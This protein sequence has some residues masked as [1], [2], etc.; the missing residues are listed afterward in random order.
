MFAA[1]LLPSPCLP[2]LLQIV[3]IRNF[4]CGQNSHLML[5][6]AS[7]YQLFCH[8]ARKSI[9]LFQ[10]VFQPFF[11]CFFFFFITCFAFQLRAINEFLIART[12]FNVKSCHN[13]CN[14]T[15]S[16]VSYSSIPPPPL[17]QLPCSHH[18]AGQVIMS[19]S[20]SCSRLVSLVCKSLKSL[21]GCNLLNAS[22]KSFHNEDCFQVNQL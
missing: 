10:R 22:V 21:S 19:G 7:I 2:E 11:C 4:V 3:N 15:T 20:C 16:W 8:F 1:S 5:C 12:L 14:R 17:V 6:V 13:S 18:S 9:K